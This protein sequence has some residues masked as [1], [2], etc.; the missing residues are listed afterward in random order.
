MDDQ[1]L[2]L[3]TDALTWERPSAQWERSMR[4]PKVWTRNLTRSSPGTPMAAG[5]VGWPGPASQRIRCGTRPP[6]AV[7][8]QNEDWPDNLVRHGGGPQHDDDSVAGVV[9]M[10]GA[11]NP[12]F[13]W[14]ALAVASP[15]GAR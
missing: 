3:I 9:L 11:V 5:R 1:A 13:L 8:V 10:E 2:N 7:C 4:L 12:G 14:S 6:R 15:A